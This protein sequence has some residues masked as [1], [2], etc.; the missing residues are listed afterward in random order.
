MRLDKRVTMSGMSRSEARKA[1]REGRVKVNGASAADPGMTVEDSCPVTVDGAPI[2]A[3][4][5]LHCMLNK[6]AGVVSAR[7]DA[8][9]RT[10]FDCLPPG[11]S[12]RRD[13][14]CV[15]RLDRDV[16]G[17][18]LF[19]TDGELAHRLISPR[20]RV[21]KVYRA[22]VDGTLRDEHVGRFA[23]GID[24]GD[25]T[26]RPAALRIVESGAESIAE[27]TVCEGRFHQVKRM[28]EAVGC[29]VTRLHR[30]REGAVVLDANLASGGS[31]ELTEA[32]I[33]SLYADTHLSAPV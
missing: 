11:V 23:A 28:F 27:L 9:F 16:T 10:V 17:L 4:V 19:T 6:P 15:G 30:L 7:E 29:P 13:L 12:M 24:L 22:W 31:R 18:L 5:P 8:R 14:V 25:F 3:F 26:A 2:T 20:W 32:E 33:E 1:I 21:P